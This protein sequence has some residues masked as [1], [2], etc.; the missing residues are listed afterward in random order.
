MIVDIQP[1]H[2]Y[3]HV[4]DMSIRYFHTFRNREAVFLWQV[5]CIRVEH[6]MLIVSKLC[7]SSPNLQIRTSV[8][9]AGVSSREYY[10]VQ[11]SEKLNQCKF[12]NRTVNLSTCTLNGV[13]TAKLITDRSSS[14]CRAQHLILRFDKGWTSCHWENKSMSTQWLVVSV[15]GD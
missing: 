15:K 9:E 12:W 8:A 3:F 1:Y 6:E 13:K 14:Y 11:V 4:L 10:T 7:K 2:F 5:F